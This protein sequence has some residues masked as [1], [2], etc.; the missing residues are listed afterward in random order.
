MFDHVTFFR[1]VSLYLMGM[2]GHS[3]LSI[4]VEI[5]DCPLVF[6]GFDS[7]SVLL[8]EEQGLCGELNVEMLI[9]SDEGSEGMML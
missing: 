1:K 4:A 8:E 3:C 6:S 2:Q 7:E 9:V 5:V